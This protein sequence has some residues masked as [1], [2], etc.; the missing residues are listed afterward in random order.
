MYRQY[1]H[2]PQNRYEKYCNFRLHVVQVVCLADWRSDLPQN[3]GKP[4]LVG[5][6]RQWLGSVPA[7]VGE[8]VKEQDSG[9][10]EP[11]PKEESVPFQMPEWSDRA[12]EADIYWCF[13]LLLGRPP[14]DEEWPSHMTRLGADLTSVVKSYLG[15]LEFAH[16]QLLDTSSS[17]DIRLASINGAS[18]Y[19]SA[20]D[21][22]IGKA[23]LSG[24]Y[25]PEVVTLFHKYLKPGMSVVDIGAN[26]GYFSI[27]S[28][29]LVGPEGHVIAVEPNAENVR[30]LEMSR[31]ANDFQNLEIM[32]MAASDRNGLLVLNA[33]ESNGTTAS[34]NANPDLLKGATLVPSVRLDSLIPRDRKLDFLK[35]DVEGAEQLALKGAAETLS[36]HKP[37]IVSEF[38]PYALPHFSGCT[39]EAYL[40]FITDLGYSL[41]VLLQ[42]GDLV[43]YGQNI[44]GIM[45]EFHSRQSDHIDI[46]AE[47]V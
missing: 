7:R 39:G 18:I 23:V 46:L 35:I 6:L 13:R 9:L 10:A 28:A 2:T 45:S 33:G 42:N 14:H 34:L 37:V 36:L 25:E 11:E 8:P 43:G 12:S 20:L 47:P 3:T 29:S 1:V 40:G 4:D 5:R 26:I 30:L 31:R 24:G 22:V 38:S 17:K 27:L 16:R 32:L 15:S 19:A 21:P 41:S 44:E